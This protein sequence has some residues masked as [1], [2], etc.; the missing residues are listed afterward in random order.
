MPHGS[1]VLVSLSSSSV[2][3]IP[4]HIYIKK[5]IEIQ[6]YLYKKIINVLYSKCDGLNENA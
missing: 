5:I 4:I 1:L 2:A 6:L 3:R